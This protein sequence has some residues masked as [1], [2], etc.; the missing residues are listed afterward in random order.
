VDIN[1][2]T[3]NL[4]DPTS[5]TTSTYFFCLEALSSNPKPDSSISPPQQFPTTGLT[6]MGSNDD[7]YDFFYDE[8]DDVFDDDHHYQQEKVTVYHQQTN[9]NFETSHLQRLTRDVVLANILPFI[10]HKKTLSTLA[11]VS[12]HFKIMMFSDEAEHIWNQTSHP[13]QFCIDSYCPNC[14]IKKRQQKGNIHGLLGFLEKCP[15][16]NLKLHCFITDIPGMYSVVHNSNRHSCLPLCSDFPLKF[17]CR[18]FIGV[19][20]NPNA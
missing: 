13:F 18:M 1:P 16:N 19:V 4:Q 15:I 11:V 20:N 14:L 6:S 12:K 17:D 5:N 8:T 2:I 3:H 9:L 7:D 10:S